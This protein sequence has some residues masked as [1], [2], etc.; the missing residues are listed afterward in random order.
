[1]ISLNEMI[2]QSKKAQEKYLSRGQDSEI[3]LRDIKNQIEKN[4]DILYQGY[5]IENTEI[6]EEIFAQ[7]IRNQYEVEINNNQEV[8]KN[9][10]GKVANIKDPYGVLGVLSDCNLFQ[11]F[12]LMILAVV[13]KNALIINLEKNVGVNYLLIQNIKDVLKR[14]ELEN[15]IEIYN[16]KLNNDEILQE[17]ENLDG[18]IFIGKRADA[19]RI[20]ILSTKP[21]IYSGCGYYDMY[22]ED[23][24][25]T[26]L[27]EKIKEN[28][29]V[30]I[31]SKIGIGIG[32]EVTGLEEAIARINEFG[33]R[34][35]VGI[36]VEDR[37]KAKEFISLIKSR[38]VFVN[39][40]PT[41]VETLDIKASDLV[42]E[43]SIL[44]YE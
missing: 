24:L 23:D 13:S 12:R 32:Q 42:C 33:N 31:Y 14:Y 38:N 8:F 28:K 9:E 20:K 22:I 2:N 5:I 16:G 21:V 25:D 39:A 40:I 44:V 35:A 3:I 43:K 7:K 29:Q 10:F 6:S 26:E 37:E 30:K 19:E 41:L 27:I 11:I 36:I 18:I 15:L 4:L 34:Y 17:N 1:M